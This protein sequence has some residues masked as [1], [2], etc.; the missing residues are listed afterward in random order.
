MPLT[1]E[2]ELHKRRR[3]LN[4]GVGLVLGGFVVL[5]FLLTFV[6]IT[7]QSM[8][9]PDNLPGTAAESAAEEG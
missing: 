1:R 8:Q 4:T 3:G 2:H 5:V 9:F 6:K 7:G